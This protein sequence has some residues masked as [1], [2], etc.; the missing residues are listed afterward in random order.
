MAEVSLVGIGTQDTTHRR[1]IETEESSAE[2]GEGADGVDVV[3]RLVTLAIA[4]AVFEDGA[5]VC[6]PSS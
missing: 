2:G 6:L 5:V 3:E 4:R 1:D